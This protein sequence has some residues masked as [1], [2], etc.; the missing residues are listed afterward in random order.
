MSPGTRTRQP[1]RG[2]ALLRGARPK[3]L[4]ELPGG[5]R[6]AQAAILIAIQAAG[7]RGLQPRAGER[8]NPIGQDG[9]RARHPQP[10]GILLGHHNLPRHPDTGKARDQRGKPIVQGFRARALWYMQDLKAD[11]MFQSATPANWGII[12]PLFKLPERFTAAG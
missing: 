9:R 12:R 3:H 11:H 7:Q 5:R 10:C 1:V 6:W 4:A 2:F 8:V